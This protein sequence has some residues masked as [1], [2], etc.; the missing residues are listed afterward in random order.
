VTVL[1]V[2]LLARLRWLLVVL[3]GSL[4][5]LLLLLLLLLRLRLL[6]LLLLTVLR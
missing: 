3:L 1:E 4:L 2:L 6:L 5:P